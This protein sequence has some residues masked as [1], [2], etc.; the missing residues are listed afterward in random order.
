MLY[1]WQEEAIEK[2]Q[3]KDVLLSAPTG[4]GKTKVAY[5][6]AEIIDKEGN[7]QNQKNRIIFTAPIKALSNERYMELKEMGLDVGLETGDF[8]KNINAPIIC[9][10]QEIYTKKY[11]ANPNQKVI[12]DEFHYVSTDPMRAR[13]Y[14]DGIVNT[15]RN[16]KILVMSATFGQPET[17][18]KYIERISGRPFTMFV[19]KER[20]TELVYL[21]N[22]VDIYKLKN[23]LIFAFSRRGVE[24][25]AYEIAENRE[26]IED[27]KI[28]K[29]EKLA[30][31]FS[32]NKVPDICYKGVGMYIGTLLPKEKLFMETAFRQNLLSIMVGTDALALGVNLPAETVVFAQLAKYYDGPISKNE[33]VQMAGR[34]GRKGYY[35]TGYVSYYPSEYESFDYDTEELYQY[36]LKAPQESMKIIIDI[37]VPDLLRGKSVREEAEYVA[38]NSIP[39]LS[40]SEVQEEIEN[41]I[42]QIDEF[43]ETT[44]IFNFKEILS[45]IYFPEYSLW[46]NLNIAKVFGEKEII[47]VIELKDLIL[48]CEESRNEFYS[49]MQLKKF[50][51]SLPKKYK[52]KIINQIMIDYLINEIDPTV[53]DFEKRIINARQV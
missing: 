17:V 3:G 49:L 36:L 52:N 19:T 28:N 18:Q 16:S 5:L 50:I 12:I 26:V 38:K 34:A 30:E 42:E 20:A 15:N 14:I 43:S 41:M 4:S 27:G 47:E 7:I 39:M 11:A 25:I 10:T 45:D 2:I 13:A 21:D 53:N 48:S 37:S 51:R 24:N 46:T 31:I 44:D 29:L 1:K 33:F 6:W 8:K 22:S 40:V 9:C 23:A 32:I 35:D